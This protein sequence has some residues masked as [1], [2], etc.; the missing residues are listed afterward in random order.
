VFAL[1]SLAVHERKHLTREQLLRQ[2][3]ATAHD[4]GAIRQFAA[5][6]RLKVVRVKSGRR[7]IV[8]RGR[9]RDMTKAFAVDLFHY[10]RGGHVFR[11]HQ[12]E[13]TVLRDLAG[14]HTG[15]NCFDG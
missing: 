7:V 11:S 8:L 9:A 3:R 15:S 2:S 13:V 4:I 6:P 10:E 14:V 5:D 12:R 1:G